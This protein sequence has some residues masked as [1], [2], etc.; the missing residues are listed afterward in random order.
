MLPRSPVRQ[1]GIC[2]A[3]SSHEVFKAHVKV[4]ARK[5]NFALPGT[6][7]TA[8]QEKSSST[9]G[10]HPMF[11]SA[12]ISMET[13]IPRPLIL[14]I[15]RVANSEAML[16]SFLAEKSLSFSLAPDLQL[17]KGMSH[18]KKALNLITIHRTSASYK[19]R[20][21]V[22][23]TIKKN[24]VEYLKEGKFSLNIAES[25]SSSNEKVVTVLVNYFKNE[26]IVTESLQ[27]FSMCQ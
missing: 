17:I 15:D 25:T 2:C 24:V 18:D 27:S 26:K 22:S 10:L 8:A 19:S 9:Y 12:E 7:Q 5:D 4:K 3:H 1:T 23:K 16:L 6:S 11:S 20:F 14:L 21:G 13:H